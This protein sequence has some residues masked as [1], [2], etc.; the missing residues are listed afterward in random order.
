MS[1]FPDL[2]DRDCVGDECTSGESLLE[3]CSLFS[4]CLS[5]DGERMIVWCSNRSFKEVDNSAG[6]GGW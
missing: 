2:D 1:V 6:E 3:V 5:E 4:D